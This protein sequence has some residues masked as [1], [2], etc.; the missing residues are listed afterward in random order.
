MR[1]P[2]GRQRGV[3]GGQVRDA[4][5]GQTVNLAGDAGLDGGS[6]KGLTG[7]WRIVEMDNWDRVETGTEVGR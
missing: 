1:R 3:L 6:V 4:A 2:R 7:R 5:G